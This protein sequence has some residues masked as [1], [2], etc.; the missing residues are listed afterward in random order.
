MVISRVAYAE[1]PQRPC[2]HTYTEQWTGSASLLMW[3]GNSVRT[4]QDKAH[5]YN[6]D[7]VIG[8]LEKMK[9]KQ[10]DYLSHVDPFTVAP[11]LTIISDNTRFLRG[12][13]RILIVGERR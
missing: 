9:F 8:I 4:H 1:L 7:T 11:N 3:L 13:H 12:E 6:F 2:R 10:S 5:H